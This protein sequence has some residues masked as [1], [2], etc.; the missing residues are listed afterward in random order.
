M[1][2]TGTPARFTCRIDDQYRNGIQQCGDLYLL[3]VGS[4][5]TWEVDPTSI[6]TCFY[7]SPALLRATAE[8]IGLDPA[9]V[10]LTPQLQ[11]RDEQIKHIAAV[12]ADAFTTGVPP[13][14]L[15]SES[16]GTAL[17]AR[18]VGRFASSRSI[19]QKNGL[20][21][22]QLQRVIDHIDAH[23]D[24][25]LSL[26]G[27]AAITGLSESHFRS[28]FRR[29][30]GLPVHQYVIRRRVAKAR[31]LL[32]RGRSISQ[33]A[34]ES[35]FADQSHMARCMRRV[36]G[37]LPLEIARLAD[38]APAHETDRELAAAAPPAPL[39]SDRTGRRSATRP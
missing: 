18:I 36:L 14:R 25:D 15:Y 20:S 24:E 26:A 7:F 33:A 8:D 27:L 4:T 23:A 17:L 34:F 22:R 5:G 16:L 32:M 37:L 10:E 3:P 30:M 35:G 39:R 21:K 11:A 2:Q 31:T 6:A 29:S 12:I 1:V 9:V 28:Q 13:G 19:R 38:R